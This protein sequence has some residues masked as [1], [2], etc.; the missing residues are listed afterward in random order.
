MITLI[1]TVEK[2]EILLDG[3]FLRSVISQLVNSQ[4]YWGPHTPDSAAPTFSFLVQSLLDTPE[5][6]YVNMFGKK[7]NRFMIQDSSQ[8]PASVTIWPGL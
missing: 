6:P 4:T 5:N 8:P 7:H 2:N 3:H 1:F